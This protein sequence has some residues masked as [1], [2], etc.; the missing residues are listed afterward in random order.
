MQRSSRKYLSTCRNKSLNTLKR[1]DD[2]SDDTE[3]FQWNST[4]RCQQ[5]TRVAEAFLVTQTF[6]CFEAAAKIADLCL[7]H[8]LPRGFF[9]DVLESLQNFSLVL[10]FLF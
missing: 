4:Y 6:R 2:K 9:F 10:K 7:L 5:F 8:K 3:T 1:R